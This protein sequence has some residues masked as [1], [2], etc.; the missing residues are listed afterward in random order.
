M[1]DAFESCNDKRLALSF[2]GDS[3]MSKT[4]VDDLNDP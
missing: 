4:A 3:S 2:E 1:D